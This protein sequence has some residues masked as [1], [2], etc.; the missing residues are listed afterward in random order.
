[1]DFVPWNDFRYFHQ[2]RLLQSHPKCKD[3]QKTH[4]TRQKRSQAK[5]RKEKFKIAMADYITKETFSTKEQRECP[6]KKKELDHET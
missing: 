6:R 2:Q 3:R 5:G 4:W 1:M